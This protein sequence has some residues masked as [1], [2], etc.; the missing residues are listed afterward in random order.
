MEMTC[1]RCHQ[2]VEEGNCFCPHCGLPQLVYESEGEAGQNPLQQWNEA[3]RDASTVAWKPALRAALLLAVPAGLLSS[4]VSP[5]GFM[6][7][8]WAALAAAWAVSI[9]VRGQRAVWI[10]IGAGARI[11]LATGLIA[12]WLAFGISGGALFVQRYVLHRA[13]QIDAEWKSRVEM[14]QQVTQQWTAGLASAN[15]TE[16]Q[17]QRGQVEARCF[18][19]GATLGLKHSDSPSMAFCCCFLPRAGEHWGRDGWPDPGGRRFSIAS[20][21]MDAG[22]LVHSLPESGGPSYDPARD[23]AAREHT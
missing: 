3:A 12:A 11:G 18:R 19:R 17:A 22:P 9:Y 10:T 20:G 6:G 8:A 7:L 1:A 2:T 21:E 23:T 15:P 4:G 16:A 14:S 13:S 5:L